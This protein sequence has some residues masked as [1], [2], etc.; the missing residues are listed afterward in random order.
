MPGG[1]KMALENPWLLVS[2]GKLLN[3]DK[4]GV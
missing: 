1:G 3:L 4:N 2:G